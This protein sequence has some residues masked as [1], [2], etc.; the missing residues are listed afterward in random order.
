MSIKSDLVGAKPL[1]MVLG[2]FDGR[3]IARPQCFAAKPQ[4]SSARN[5]GEY[6][7][8]VSVVQDSVGG[9]VF[10]VDGDEKF[11]FSQVGI[12]LSELP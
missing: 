11:V 10:F 8:F 4:V 1:R 5:G 7:N 6:R 9:C 12:R 3:A 2:G